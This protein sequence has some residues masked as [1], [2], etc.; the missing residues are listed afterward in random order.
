MCSFNACGLIEKSLFLWHVSANLDLDQRTFSLNRISSQFKPRMK[1][2]VVFSLGFPHKSILS[3]E[4]GNFNVNDNFEIAQLFQRSWAISEDLSNSKYPNHPW[5]NTLY[6]LF[7]DR[8]PL[9]S[10]IHGI[11]NAELLIVEI[12]IFCV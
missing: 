3:I 9:L 11:I 8:S 2:N 6:R 10:D 12:S 5:K 1:L 4:A 7:S